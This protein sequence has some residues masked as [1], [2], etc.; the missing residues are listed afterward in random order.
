MV[1]N[2]QDLRD[3]VALCLQRSECVMLH[4][5]TPSE[6]LNNPELN[7]DL[8]QQC[9]IH[10]LR[11]MDCKRGQADR[12]KRFR[13]NGPK[14]TGKYVSDLELLQSGDFDPST[15]LQKLSATQH[16]TP[17]AEVPK[18]EAPVSEQKSKSKSK[19]WPF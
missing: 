18:P 3:A 5:H 10:I 11:Y 19:W 1:A 7:R 17:K 6:C 2:C 12:S 4:R 16:V 13:G 9:M 14:S 15:E 8:P